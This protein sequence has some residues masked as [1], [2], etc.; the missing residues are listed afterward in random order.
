[1]SNCKAPSVF[2]LNV[3]PSHPLNQ[4]TRQATHPPFDQHAYTAK[5]QHI[6]C[7]PIPHTLRLRY[8]P[9]AHGQSR[10][11]F[12]SRWRSQ[13]SKLLRLLTESN[14]RDQLAIV[15]PSPPQPS[16]TFRMY[17]GLPPSSGCDIHMFSI[18]LHSD[19]SVSVAIPAH[20]YSSHHIADCPQPSCL[21]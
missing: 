17:D 12:L 8:E 18:P 2:S 9:H 16:H 21:L 19:A 5:L 7:K 3:L 10:E 20:I 6:V 13:Q 14:N 4:P 1:M 15:A 11:F